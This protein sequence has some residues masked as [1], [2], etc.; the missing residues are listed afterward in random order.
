MNGIVSESAEGRGSASREEAVDRRTF[1]GQSALASWGAVSSL[2]SGRRVRVGTGRGPSPFR[3]G[4][5]SGDPLADRVIIWTRVTTQ[6]PGPVGVS[7][8]VARDPQ[9][10]DVVAGGL[11]VTDKTLDFTVKVDV[12]GLEAATTYYYGFRAL[13]AD[14]LTGRTRTAPVGAT[15]SVRFALVSCSSFAAGYFN[16]YARIAARSD[17]DFVVH[18]GDYIYESG[19]RSTRAHHP[20]RELRTLAEYRARHAQYRQDPDLQRAHQHQAFVLV[21]DDHEI[22]N[23]AWRGGAGAHQAGSDGDWERRKRSAVQAYREWMPIRWPSADPIRIWRH[24]PFGDLLDLVM[25]DTRLWARNTPGTSTRWNDPSSNDSGRRMLGE[26]QY[27]FLTSTLA[28]SGD[29]G[30]AWRVMGNQT[31]MSPHRVDRTDPPLPYLPEEVVEELGTRQGGGNEGADNWGAYLVER[32]RLIRFLRD[33]AISNNVVLTGDVHSAWACEI[34]EDPHNPALYDPVTGRGSVG[35]ELVCTSVSS[36]NL[37]ERDPDRAPASNLAIVAS[38]PNV[39]YCDL[40]AH[41]YTLVD[42]TPERMQAE[43]YETGTARERSTSEQVA[44][45]ARVVAGTNHATLAAPGIY[46]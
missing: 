41:G 17:L 39:A 29:R 34:V 21:W 26:E 7:W 24:L 1:L 30:V 40:A 37:R 10:R 31:M 15:K 25:L 28:Q 32:D 45:G 42:V 33:N 13:G 19:A 14:S 44:A 9:L 12:T 27:R 11:T 16:A 5:A 36:H 22:A 20:P 38:N 46:S 18:V 2:L 23:D 43:W 6:W 4:V 8:R 3:H 35:V